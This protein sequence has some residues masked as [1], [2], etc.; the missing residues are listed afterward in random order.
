MKLNVIHVA[1]AKHLNCKD[2]EEV[3]DRYPQHLTV[4]QISA[5]QLAFKGIVSVPAT[6]LVVSRKHVGG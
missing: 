1:L 6:W 4:E 5:F 3:V 2:F